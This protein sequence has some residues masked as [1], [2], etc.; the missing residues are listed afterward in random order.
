MGFEALDLASPH[1][2]HPRGVL[3]CVD[4]LC[5]WLGRK[6]RSNHAGFLSLPWGNG[7]WWQLL[8]IS[9]R[10]MS[11]LLGRWTEICHNEAT[12]VLV[13]DTVVVLICDIV[14]CGIQGHVDFDSLDSLK[15]SGVA[16]L[17][18]RLSQD[19]I[20]KFP[21]HLCQSWKCVTKSTATNVTKWKKQ[22]TLEVR[23]FL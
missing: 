16:E 9:V 1:N 4:Q 12:Q 8:F 2:P 3:T 13:Y 19:V 14:S 17:M 10:N 7:F 11:L 5:I 6:Y 18:S 20:E 21:K 22:R 23:Y 15:L